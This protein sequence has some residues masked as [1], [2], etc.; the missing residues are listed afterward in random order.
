MIAGRL[1]SVGREG[2][3]M[4]EAGRCRELRRLASW[5]CILRS[6]I[7]RISLKTYHIT[8]RS[9]MKSRE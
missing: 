1:E 7:A 4:F 5:C 9:P 8:V 3:E 6:S 2:V